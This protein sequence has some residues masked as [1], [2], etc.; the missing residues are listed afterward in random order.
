[1]NQ[2][3]YYEPKVSVHFLSVESGFAQSKLYDRNQDSE[4]A[5]LESPTFELW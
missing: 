1:M 5:G 2:K 4:A 3:K